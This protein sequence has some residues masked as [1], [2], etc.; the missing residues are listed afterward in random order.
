MRTLGQQRAEFALNK[1]MSI[2]V[3][4]EFA[5]LANG[6]PSMILQNGLGLT[7]AFWKQKGNGNSGE[8]YTQ[9]LGWVR[10]WLNARK[11]ISSSDVASF[12]TALSKT[13]QMDYIKA[14]R[15]TLALLEWVK[16]YANGFKPKSKQ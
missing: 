12:F 9:L 8:R 10:E 15:E 11:I 7:A 5:S 1:V 13:D 2:E 14:Q 6:A 4:D 16:R 3:N